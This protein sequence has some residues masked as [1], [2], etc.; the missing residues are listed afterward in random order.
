MVS[1]M[2]R[3]PEVEEPRAA[4]PASQ[5]QEASRGQW[6]PRGQVGWPDVT[7]GRG[8]GGLRS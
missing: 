6:R 7:A 5:K 4:K 8:R 2:M 3:L 1:Q